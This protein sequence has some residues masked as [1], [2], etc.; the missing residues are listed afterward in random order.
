MPKFLFIRLSSIGDIVL[1]SPVI[2]CTKQQVPD[3][4]IHFITK[5]SFSQILES[6]PYVDKI[7]IW[8]DVLKSG[9]G[10]LRK[11]HYD[12][13]IDLHNNLRSMRLRIQLIGTPSFGFPKLNFRKY[14]MVRLK[15]NRLPKLHIVDRY[16]EAVKSLDVKNDGHGLDYFI[17]SSGYEVFKDFVEKESFKNKYIAVCIGAQHA[18]KKMS[19]KQIA[20][21]IEKLTLPVLLLGGD[22]D[23]D[24]AKEI[25]LLTTKID[26]RD[27][28]GK[29]SLHGSAAA[30][31]SA[32]LVISHD[33]GLMHIAAA[34]GKSII[35]IWGNT[36]PAFGMYAYPKNEAQIAINAE[37][38][39][40]ACRP[41]SKIGFNKCPK[42]H[43]DCMNKQDLNQIAEKANQII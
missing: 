34:L 17:A 30:L 43:F 38:K 1:T 15:M 13:V 35:S 10:L 14:L 19:A 6:N 29:L 9:F 23:K 21:L 37:V 32:H 4:E 16:F 36:I 3:A 12:A 26:V 40:L 8:E 28:C 27:A 22:S 11:E 39:G 42:G 5:A 31:Q 24:S 20:K 2:R 25:K 7:L 41:C 18:T 33:T